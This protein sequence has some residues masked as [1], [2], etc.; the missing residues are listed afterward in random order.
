MSIELPSN[1]GPVLPA[2][3]TADVTIRATIA[4]AAVLYN[5]LVR[6]GADL[7]Q[8]QEAN[9]P[10][11]LSLMRLQVNRMPGKFEEMV[12]KIYREWPDLPQPPE[13]PEAARE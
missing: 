4:A 6:L 13:I 9:V 1:N 7:A 8:D 11:A 2:P 5:N 12:T 3:D 10:K